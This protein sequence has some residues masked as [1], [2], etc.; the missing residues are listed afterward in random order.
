MTSMNASINETDVPP[1]SVRELSVAVSLLT[2]H[3]AS[4]Q[5]AHAMTDAALGEVF[6]AYWILVS[7]DGVRK[8]ATLVRLQS[9]INVCSAR[10]VQRLFATHGR[11][12]I[13][14][15]VTAAAT[16]RLNLTYGFN[17]LKIGRAVHIAMATQAQFDKQAA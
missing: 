10:R 17:P 11:A 9:L 13:A 15:A 12:G 1:V 5:T 2:L 16:S 14:H 8:T 3:G 7:R 4:L 6:T